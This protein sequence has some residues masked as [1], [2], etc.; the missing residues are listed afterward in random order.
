MG[1]KGTIRSIQATANRI[2][3]ESRKRERE[4]EKRRKEIE[5]METLEHAMFEVEEYENYIE[6][7]QSIHKES[8]QPI[9]WTK[10]LNEK[11]PKKPILN[12]KKVKYLMNEYENFKGSF[13]QRL[14]K[15]VEQN[16][17]KLKLE[18]EEIKKTSNLK[19]KK[20]LKDYDLLVEELKDRK[21]NAKKII[22]KDEDSV[23]EFLKEV[24]PFSEIDN[25]GS[26]LRLFFEK[27]KLNIDLNVHSKEIIPLEI[28]SLLKSGKLSIKKMPKGQ[29]YEIYQDYVCSAVLRVAREIFSL[30]PINEVIITAEDEL[31]D[32]KTGH[33]VLK[34]ILSI[35][36]VRKTFENLNLDL[37]DPSDSMENFL[38]NMN[39]KK[40]TGFYPIERIDF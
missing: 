27:G 11:I 17:E 21:E 3:R 20:D 35:F 7:V 18:I 15:T 14:F 16:K 5:K 12:D 4:L 22:D 19:Y 29:Y 23:L 24:E 28:K 39:F 37:I 33:K 9:N 10:I 25:L 34:P 36:I 2:E 32:T 40:T 8:S 31:L 30:L 13:F 1:W 38:F 6:R 26:Q